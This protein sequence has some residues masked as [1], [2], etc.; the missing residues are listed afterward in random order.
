ML[1]AGGTGVLIKK[2]FDDIAGMISDEEYDE[3]EE[4]EGSE[5]SEEVESSAV[6]STKN[7]INDQP[8]VDKNEATSQIMNK[9]DE[10]A[11]TTI[12]EGGD[13][14]LE[15]KIEK[16]LEDLHIMHSNGEAS[17]SGQNVPERRPYGWMDLPN[18]H[19]GTIRV[20]EIMKR[21]EP[22]R[23]AKILQ[24]AKDAMMFRHR[25]DAPDEVNARLHEFD[26]EGTDDPDKFAAPKTQE[27]DDVQGSDVA[28]NG[29][30]AAGEDGYDGSYRGPG[31]QERGL[32]TDIPLVLG[33]TEIDPLP[34][35]IRDGIFRFPQKES[36]VEDENRERYGKDVKNMQSVRCNI[37]LA[38]DAGRNLLRE[39]LIFIA[40]WDLQD[41]DTYFKL[42]IQIMQAILDNGLMPFA[43]QAFG[44]EKDIVSPAQS[45][46]IKILTQIFRGKQNPP[47]PNRGPIPAGLSS[48]PDSSSRMDIVVRNIF[49]T[50]RQ[51]I[52]P[53]TCA[54]IYLQGQIR[55]NAA[56]PEA[57]PLNLWDMERVYE[58]VYQ[59]LEFFA[60]LTESE[61]WK[62]KLVEWEIVSELV[63]LLRELDV[64]IPKPCT[65][66]VP[67]TAAKMEAATY[68]TAA[69]GE[70]QTII[71][72][73][74]VERPYDQTPSDAAWRPDYVDRGTSETPSAAIDN[75][76]ASEF[77]WRNLKKLVVLV[78][79]SLVWK[80]SVV[81]N[82]IRQYGGVE[83]VLACCNID[84]NNPY[85]REHA[86]MCLR[87][88]L[89]GNK[90]N[91]EI[92]R[93]LVPRKT[94]PDEVLDKRGYETYID[95]EGKVGLRAKE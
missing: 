49:L 13:A 32:L 70:K 59:F 73:V 51:A 60:V 44:E 19:T 57:F 74:A 29:S 2:C 86:I 93:S 9:A 38:Q 4:S 68:T 5:G 80:S 12:T 7:T 61:E 47:D 20:D 63:T 23:A 64:S 53:E 85:I 37:L 27:D 3:Y 30:L 56:S 18:I 52:I 75:Q 92:V 41:D 62:C 25:Q 34:L 22:Q 39:L 45:M 36:E 48:H 87:F 6:G 76:E 16:K 33:P 91:Q 24:D 21:C 67:A 55:A 81:Q 28:A 40:A 14:E 65:L 26:G 84:D 31:D 88:L 46:I 15:E 10:T 1:A 78:L 71:A 82:Q 42:M 89:E 72:P 11:D 95:E 90:E 94:V 69:D 35:I 77:E 83:M 8:I 50:F 17:D 58:G 79:S 54:L 66:A 43:Y